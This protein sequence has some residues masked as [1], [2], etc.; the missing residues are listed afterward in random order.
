VINHQ[1]VVVRPWQGLDG[2]NAWR[3]TSYS[4]MS[5]GRGVE[6][7]ER[8]KPDDAAPEATASA[9]PTDTTDALRPPERPTEAERALAPGAAFFGGT[10][11]GDL[12]HAIFEHLNFE[13]QPPRA[14][15]GAPLA[16]LITAQGAR[17]GFT[18]P[19]AAPQLALA[20]ALVPG[21]LDTPLR[22]PGGE[23]R[24][25][26][27][28]A[29][30]RG[31]ELAFDLRLGAGLERVRRGGVKPAA[32]R[33][34]LDAAVT[35]KTCK[36]ARWLQPLL[37][38][39]DAKAAAEA[40]KKGEEPKVVGLIPAIQGILNGSIDLAFQAKANDGTPR[41]FVA[42]YKSNQLKGSLQSQQITQAWPLPEP[43][44]AG[45][46]PGALRRWHYSQNNLAWG[47]AHAGYHLQS[48]IYTVALHRWLLRRVRGYSYSAH[49]G[50][51]FYLYLRGMEGGDSDQGVWF[52]RWPEATV[53]GLDAALNGADRS[54]VADLIARVRA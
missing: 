9:E 54:T 12:L 45:A 23:V 33:E 31:D 39:L 34:A 42:D 50:G 28:T 46:H 38:S 11:T 17:F 36:A 24:L 43:A 15:D 1:T 26:Q 32:A 4:G 6:L 3:V 16:E 53:L 52:D 41:Y 19:K 10:K 14:K 5:A 20:E 40:A 22:F 30:D 47:M 13:A 29:A 18:R 51:H 27:L 37:A 35:D 49:F 44:P 2:W 48:L 25:R 21:W 8:R 7:D